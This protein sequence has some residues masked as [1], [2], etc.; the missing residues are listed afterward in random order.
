MEKDICKKVCIYEITPH[1]LR[2]AMQDA[3]VL[4]IDVRERIEH[5]EARI[6]GAINVPLS[7]VC[8]EIVQGTGKK[9][10]IHCKGG[11]RSTRACQKLIKEGFE[12]QIW[13][14]QGGIDQWEAAG[15]PLLRESVKVISLQR[16][17]HLVFA[18]F[19]ILSLSLGYFVNPWFFIIQIFMV[20]G[21]C[22]SGLFNVCFLNMVLS[23]MFW[24][25][26]RPK[27]TCNTR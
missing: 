26:P 25:N 7:Q 4:V 18:L 10:I 16:Q 11:G 14:F 23:K 1:E 15:L 20:V 13:D 12:G 9:I 19:I 2:N 24:N 8:L 17:T 22:I 27:T 21:W 6:E 5:R 3:N